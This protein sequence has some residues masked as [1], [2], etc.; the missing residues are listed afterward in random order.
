[1]FADDHSVQIDV[2][3]QELGRYFAGRDHSTILHGIRTIDE[4]MKTD[5]EL[6]FQ[7]DQITKKLGNLHGLN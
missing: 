5:S 6:R 3:L 4:K 1:M 7:Y 2:T